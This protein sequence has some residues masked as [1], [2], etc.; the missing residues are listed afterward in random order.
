[1]LIYSSFKYLAGGEIQYG[2]LILLPRKY[3]GRQVLDSLRSF[4]EKKILLSWQATAVSKGFIQ[5]LFIVYLPVQKDRGIIILKKLKIF[6][7]LCYLWCLSC[8]MQDLCGIMWDLLLR[9]T[10]C[11]VVAHGFSCCSVRA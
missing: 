10:D 11:L 5:T 6:I 2:S 1:M 8:G 4:P 9:R 7:Y 3:L